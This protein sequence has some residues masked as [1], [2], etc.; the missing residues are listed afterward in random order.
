MSGYY[1]EGAW[2]SAE[3]TVD[4]WQQGNRLS[5]RQLPTVNR[6]PT[7]R[8]QLSISVNMAPATFVQLLKEAAKRW[9]ERDAFQHAGALGFFTLF[10]LAPLVIIL[11]AIVGAV[12]GEEAASGEISAA[13]GDLV[14]AQAASAV[15]E[16]VRRS[17]LEE[18]GIL[19]TI[20]GIGALL[21]GAT[22]VFAQMQSS[23]NQFWD[24]RAKPTRSGIINFIT[25]RLLSLSMVLIIGFLLLT[26]FVISVAITGII[27][28]ANDWIPVPPIAIAA[29]D[30]AVSLSVSTLLFGMIFKVLPDVRLRWSDVWRGALMTAVLFAI[31]K[32][33]ISLYL[34]HVAP[35]STYGAAG[36]LVLIL[37]WVYYS[38]L[39]LFFGTSLTAVTILRRDG[40]ITPKS[41]AV[42]TSF[43]VH[44]E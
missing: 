7:T 26:S 36:S 29:I 14:G 30:L 12:Y 15:E 10:S 41:T 35:A 9:L 6:P 24:V 44:D 16:A 42:R 2:S 43:I 33:L 3:L 18:A 8:M 28:Y 31:G 21:F 22:T 32:Y 25:V 20:L 34:T 5:G 37:L 27:E 13:I 19:P 11:V 4:S 23:L 40:V 38:S 39:I 17:R 1:P